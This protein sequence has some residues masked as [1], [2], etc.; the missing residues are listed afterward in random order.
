MSRARLPTGH[1]RAMARALTVIYYP[2]DL[3]SYVHVRVSAVAD[4]SPVR[5][6]GVRG[7]PPA[8]HFL[9]DFARRRPAI[10]IFG[11]PTQRA[12]AVSRV[13][14]GSTRR[15]STTRVAQPHRAERAADIPP[16]PDGCARGPGLCGNAALALRTGLGADPD[17]RVPAPGHGYRE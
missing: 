2:I 3:R 13:S 9:G 15:H 14:R 8:R 17:R 11:V 6:T 16:G 5:P 7:A 10:R 4:P 12:H 1:A